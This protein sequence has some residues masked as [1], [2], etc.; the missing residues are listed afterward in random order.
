M[1]ASQGCWGQGG[2]GCSFIDAVKPGPH[3]QGRFVG[4]SSSKWRRDVRQNAFWR[5]R[6]LLVIFLLNLFPTNSLKSFFK[7]WL[8][9]RADASN[10]FFWTCHTITTTDHLMPKNPAALQSRPQPSRPKIWQKHH[11]HMSP[12]TCRIRKS[13]QLPHHSVWPR[14]LHRTNRP[15]GISFTT[16]IQVF[17]P[18]VVC[19]FIPESHLL[20]TCDNTSGP[21]KLTWNPVLVSP[22]S[23][24]L[25]AMLHCVLTQCVCLSST[26]CLPFQCCKV[27]PCKV[28]CRV[29]LRQNPCGKPFLW[30]QTMN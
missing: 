27:L 21:P 2:G 13:P 28:F 26:P 7:I 11:D 10:Q 23:H 29:F 1:R 20:W 14:Q 12:L 6:N 24:S 18:D 19:H 3:N 22:L 16:D 4:K 8:R 9:D 15:S 25:L 17:F 30:R 5:A